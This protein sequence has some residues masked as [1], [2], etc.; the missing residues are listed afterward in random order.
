[1]KQKSWRQ[2]A[3]ELGVSASYLSQVRHGK[4]P[5]SQKVLSKML[6]NVKQK[7]DTTK[8]NSYNSTYAGVAEQADAADLKSAGVILVGSSPTPGTS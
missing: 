2:L 4:R 5:P 8:S 6:S 7:V 3:K 1:M